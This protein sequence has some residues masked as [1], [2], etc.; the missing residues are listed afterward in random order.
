MG[1]VT[2]GARVTLNINYAAGHRSANNAFRFVYTCTDTTQNGVEAAPALTA[3]ANACTATV[4]GAPAPYTDPAG[5]AAPDAIV[6][7]G[8]TV[9][10][11][12]PLQNVVAQTECTMSLLDQRDWGGCVDVNVLP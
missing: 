12:L 4:A 5:V 9:T 7:G 3:A 6:P 10:C 11:T 1:A 8:Y 2:D